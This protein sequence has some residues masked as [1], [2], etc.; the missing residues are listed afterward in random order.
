VQLPELLRTADGDDP[1]WRPGCLGRWKEDRVGCEEPEGEKRAGGNEYRASDLSGQL[2]TVAS[3]WAV[4][5]SVLGWDGH[6]PSPLHFCLA[7]THNNAVTSISC[8]Y[9]TTYIEESLMRSKRHYTARF[10]GVPISAVRRCT[11]QQPS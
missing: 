11:I 4:Y 1:A 8:R 6:R 3:V 10:Q 7:I 9:T 2:Q 5:R